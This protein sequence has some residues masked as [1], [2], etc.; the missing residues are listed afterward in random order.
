M[1]TAKTT[2]DKTF[3]DR[4]P[5]DRFEHRRSEPDLDRRYGRIAISAL[6]AVLPYRS[7]TRSEG[8]APSKARADRAA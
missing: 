6:V 5:G 2:S 3:G 8:H 7:E 4:M 1:T